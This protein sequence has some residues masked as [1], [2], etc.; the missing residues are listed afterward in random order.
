MHFVDELIQG[1]SRKAIYN[2]RMTGD[3]KSFIIKP[4]DVSE[5][6]HS[7]DKAAAVS[8]FLQNPLAVIAAATTEYLAHGPSAVTAPAV[9][10]AHAALKGKLRQQWAQEIIALREKGM[11]ASDF[12]E[13]KYGFQTWI[14]LLTIIDEDTPDE[15]RLE[16]LKAMFYAAN[17]IKATDAEQIISYQLFQIAKKLS[18]NELLILRSAYKLQQRGALRGGGVMA[19]N[20][21]AESI[22][23]ELG[24]NLVPLIEHA[25]DVLVGN[26]LLSHRYQKENHDGGQVIP[27]NAR[28]TD[29]GIRF[30]EN[31]QRYQIE[32]KS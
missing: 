1:E 27:I 13:R 19:F 12:A 14:E 17:N 32:K 23:G 25:D 20:Q 24:H 8:E 21:W 6:I 2:L 26:K 31:V 22:G 18:S 5:I 16:A 9:R 3:D 30:C 28:L 29:L 10:L 4:R 11:I 7:E 15:D